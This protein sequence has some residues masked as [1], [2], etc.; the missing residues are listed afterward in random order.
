MG[1]EDVLPGTDVVLPPW[2]IIIRVWSD[3]APEWDLGGLD[4]YIR[5][6]ALFEVLQAIEDLMD[7]KQDEEDG[8]GSDE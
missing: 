5:Y 7:A 8:E 3:R 4:D 6:A 2:T 1:S